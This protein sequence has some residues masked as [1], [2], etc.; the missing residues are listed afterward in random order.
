MRR[1]KGFT[2]IELLVVI[3]II[4]IL[5]AMLLPAL[6]TARER[7]RSASC[8]NNMRQLGLASQMYANDF[9]DFLIISGFWNIGGW[10]PTMRYFSHPDDGRG[11][12]P[13]LGTWVC[14]SFPPYGWDD[15]PGTAYGVIRGADSSDPPADDFADA[16]VPERMRGGLRYAYDEDGNWLHRWGAYV[17]FAR[18]GDPSNY[19]LIAE[20]SSMARMEQ[21]SSWQLRHSS[22]NQ[23]MRHGEEATNLL[24]ADGHVETAD[25]GRAADLGLESVFSHDM[26]EEIIF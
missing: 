26:S 23:H 13:Q 10:W 5:A 24:F 15:E 7:A 16:K 25:Q 14:P 9:D 22:T 8:V 6:N 17:H 2:L 21:T 19:F 20:N 11:Y 1:E 3:A 12:M 18:I 4:A